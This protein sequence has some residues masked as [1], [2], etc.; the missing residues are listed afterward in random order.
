MKLKKYLDKND[1]FWGKVRE[2]KKRGKD[3]GFPTANVA[4][5][6]QVSEG[7]YISQT[8]VQNKWY[9]S[10]T[11][12]GSAK[13]FNEKKYQSE[14]YIFSFNETIYNK[15]ITVKLLKYIR[16]NKKFSSVEVL[17]KEMKQ[18]ETRA[19]DYFNNRTMK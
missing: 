19:K 15:W 9:P 3:F 5:A 7:V 17:I 4:L 13:T 10:L 11:F 16:G 14:T 18:D 2:G 12:I 1:I 6:K 8:K